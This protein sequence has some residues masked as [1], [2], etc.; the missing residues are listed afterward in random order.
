MR[1]NLD[2]NGPF[3]GKVAAVVVNL[4]GALLSA[5]D[6][7][8]NSMWFSIMPL[9]FDNYE[10]TMKQERHEYLATMERC[11]PANPEVEEN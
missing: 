1:E 11:Y 9:P 2:F 8:H 5:H 7:I 4:E 10:V 6:G 3:M